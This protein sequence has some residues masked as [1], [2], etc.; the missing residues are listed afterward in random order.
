MQKLN[1]MSGEE[2]RR[3]KNNDPQFVK[4]LATFGIKIQ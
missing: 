1:K 4:E 2:I 3:K